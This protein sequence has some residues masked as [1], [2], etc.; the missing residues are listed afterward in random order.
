MC[1]GSHTELG[2]AVAVDPGST[3]ER[4]R[5]GQ[6][7]NQLGGRIEGDG[8]GHFIHLP[9]QHQLPAYIIKTDIIA[10]NT[11][12]QDNYTKCTKE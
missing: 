9:N 1:R 10:C 5:D 6:T 4:K 2:Q 12:Q 3:L 7:V 8:I 11:T